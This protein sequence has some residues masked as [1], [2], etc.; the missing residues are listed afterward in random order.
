LNTTASGGMVDTHP[1]ARLLGDIMSGRI[2]FGPRSG[3]PN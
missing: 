2:S 1:A 3:H